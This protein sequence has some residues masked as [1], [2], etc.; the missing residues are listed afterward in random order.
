MVAIVWLVRRQF[1]LPIWFGVATLL[2]YQY[3]MV[4]FGLLIGSAAVFLAARLTPTAVGAARMAPLVSLVVLAV[5]LVFE[6]GASVLAVQNPGAPLHALS[7]ER[8]E[9][10]AWVDANLEPE[11][12]LAVI[13]NSVWSGDPDSEWFYLLAARRSVATVQG[14]EWLGEAAFD[15]QVTANRALQGC[16]EPA[17]VSCV[18]DW[19][20]EWGADYVYLPKGPLRGPGG[21]DDCCAELR[22]ELAAADGFE[23]IYDGPGATI[24]AWTAP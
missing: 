6:A 9:A 22:A 14:S 1:L 17:S 23:P 24:L 21:P 10:M 19:L 7:A 3:G 12:E 4:P 11:A 8:R 5:A 15:E 2:S 18:E 16:V 13:T 20:V